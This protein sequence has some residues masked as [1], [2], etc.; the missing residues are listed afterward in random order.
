MW[1]SGWPPAKAR[2]RPSGSGRLGVSAWVDPY[3][4]RRNM[5][6]VSKIT[7][8]KPTSGRQPMCDNDLLH[9][10]QFRNAGQNWALRE[11]VFAMRKIANSRSR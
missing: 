11:G 2:R 10:L 4:E 8:T 1:Q 5:G 6:R 9:L 3:D 7:A